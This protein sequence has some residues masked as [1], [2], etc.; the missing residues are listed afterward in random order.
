MVV[1]AL[2]KWDGGYLLREMDL[3]GSLLPVQFWWF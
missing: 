3:V 1:E 2:K